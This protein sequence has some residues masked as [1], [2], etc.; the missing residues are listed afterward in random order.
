MSIRKRILTSLLI[1]GAISVT[2]ALASLMLASQVGQ[3]HRVELPME[4]DLG[5]VEISIWEALHTANTFKT[6]H[7]PAF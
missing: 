2:A 7:D 5:E 3:L 6:T 4:Q 1:V